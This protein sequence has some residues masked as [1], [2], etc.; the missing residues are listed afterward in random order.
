MPETDT[1]HNGPDTDTP[2]WQFA[3]ALWQQDAARDLLLCLQEQGWSVTRLLCAAWLASQGAAWS[4]NEPQAIQQWRRNVT[5]SIRSLKKSLDK[6]DS[7]LTPLRES[8]AR[9]ELEA[10]RV[11]L[12]RAWLAIRETEPAD[13]P[14]DVDR[15]AEYNLRQAAPANTSSNDTTE[16]MI[17]HL[18][19]LISATSHGTPDQPRGQGA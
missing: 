16:P 7:L 8:L 19:Q 10:E 15:M 4:G 9:S 5:E 1:R 3:L 18:A 14:V 6:S 12:Y 11:E 2:L 17:R 13:S